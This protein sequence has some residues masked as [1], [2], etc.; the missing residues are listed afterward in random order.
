M[1]ANSLCHLDQS[2]AR[3]G[4]DRYSNVQPWD[5]YRVKL[6]EPVG[7]SDYI[8]ASYIRLKRS[9]RDPTVEYIATQGP[10]EGQYL[11]FWQMVMQETV[12]DFG[13]IIMLTKLYEGGQQKCAQ[14]FP[15]DMDNPVMV[16]R[17]T[18][19]DTL[20]DPAL[21]DAVAESGD[22]AVTGWTAEAPITVTL[23]FPAF[24]SLRGFE[25]RDLQVE[26]HGRCITVQHYLLESWPDFGR[27]ED[28]VLDAL[29]Y[30]MRQS[31]KMAGGSPRIVHGS[32]GV[33]RTGTWIALDYLWHELE[34]GRLFV[35]KN[36][37]STRNSTVRDER[38]VDC[39]F[40]TVNRLRKQRMRM[41]SNEVQLR[42]IYEALRDAFVKKSAGFR[43]TDP[44]R[45]QRSVAQEARD[46]SEREA[47]AVGPGTR[48]QLQITSAEPGRPRLER[49][50][51]T[52]RGKHIVIVHD[53]HP[54]RHRHTEYEPHRVPPDPD[55]M[56]VIED[57]HDRDRQRDKRRRGRL[58]RRD[59]EDGLTLTDVQLRRQIAYRD[60]EREVL[61]NE[62]YEL[63]R[64]RREA[65]KRV[66]LAEDQLRREIADLER[67][68]RM[69]ER[70]ERGYKPDQLHEVLRPESRLQ[71]EVV[72]TTVG[73][74]L[75]RA[76]STDA[77]KSPSRKGRDILK[78][79]RSQ[80]DRPR[81]L[82]QEL[83]QTLNDFQRKR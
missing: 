58:E 10:K 40:D 66:I 62:L 27:P 56:L 63:R 75:R 5:A 77:T 34:A 22:E 7:G 13:V 74:S 55:K 42:F 51:D 21:E 52:D 65:E 83:E 67:E 70:E 16:V 41:V 46:F 71:V 53:P 15:P 14:Y 19:I 9:G 73:R 3:R 1:E 54:G 32:A 8:N 24:E 47:S 23:R 31:R 6:R 37:S 29:R 48:G 59:A 33:G 80:L 11:P 18:E 38:E 69:T 81:V 2:E 43:E 79:A 30:S 45:I 72:P 68:R 28:K 64:A 39:I 76:R 26:R 4:R 60:R 78:D 82:D 49:A 61:E 20:R 12:G 44:S 25:I 36:I 57:E 35:P 50:G 17:D